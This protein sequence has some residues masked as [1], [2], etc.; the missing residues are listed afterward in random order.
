ME[1]PGEY[2]RTQ[3]ENR[4]LSLTEVAKSTRIQTNILHAIEEGREDLLPH[5]FY[6]RA[7][8]TTYAKY[9]GLDP[10][11]IISRSQRNL[12]TPS[13]APTPIEP[14][15]RIRSPR[16][17]GVGRPLF[18][19]IFAMS[20]F[21]LLLFYYASDFSVELDSQHSAEKY[22]TAALSS[23]PSAIPSTRATQAK[24]ETR[25]SIESTPYDVSEPAPS[26]EPSPSFEIVEAAVGNELET[27]GGILKLTG[28]C[29]EFACNNQKV[30][31]LTRTNGKKEGKLT[32]VWSWKGTEF[33]RIEIDIKPPTRSVYSYFTLR[34]NHIG[35]WTVEVRDGDSILEG[36]A[37]KA[38]ATDTYS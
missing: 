31:F 16:K 3:R 5:P 1:Y 18:P 33:Y 8:L 36:I 10:S 20:L 25:F 7:F 30:Y 29:A 9:L 35:D 22:V 19:L 38:T 26:K 15:Y 13:P 32:H 21:F 34:P 14:K 28:T 17:S 11:D 12:N 23:V 27:E 37:F 24:S 2:L 6:L 4:N